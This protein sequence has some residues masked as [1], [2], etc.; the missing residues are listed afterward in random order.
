M[1][2][3]T[4]GITGTATKDPGAGLAARR[5]KLEP[6]DYEVG[7]L[8]HL[9]AERERLTDLR[10]RSFDAAPV[11]ATIGAE[12]SGVDLGMELPDAVIAELRQA[13]LDYKVL[14]FRGQALTAD[15]HVA[16]ARRF[17]E[18]EVHPFIPANGDHPE[19]V[20]FAKSADVGGYENGWHSDVSWRAEPSMAAVLHAVAVPPSGGDTLFADMY[21]AY[22]GLP[23]ELRERIEGLRAVH[24]YLKAFG[25]QVPPEQRDETR[26]KFPLVE[27]PVVR[28]HPETGRRLL[29]VNRFFTSHVVGLEPDSS[30]ELLERL[31]RQADVVEYQCRFR[32]MP[33][34]VVMWDNRAV[35]HY[36]C[37][38]YWPSVRVMERASIVGDRPV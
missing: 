2:T 26:A 9:A 32:W 33:D 23:E 10:W 38:D 4:D 16:F 36:A 27:H 11:A 19:L 14:C 22:D 15:R 29:Y 28:T 21:A 37:S 34:T 30:R 20:R 7:P 6:F 5:V 18:L 8:G 17:G 35:Q 13:L 1:T 3:R 12:I 24:D 25:G 31:C